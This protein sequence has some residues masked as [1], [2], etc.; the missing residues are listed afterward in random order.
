MAQYNL[1]ERVH[2]LLDEAERAECFADESPEAMDHYRKCLKR[3]HDLKSKN[4]VALL[5][6]EGEL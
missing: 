3:L 1:L 4:I 5:A 2:E 6:I